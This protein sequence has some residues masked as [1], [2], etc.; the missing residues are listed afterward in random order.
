M[1]KNKGVV[2]TGTVDDIWPYVNSV[3]VFVFP[4]W[5]GGG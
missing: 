1:G 5:I 4:I 3:D 2:V